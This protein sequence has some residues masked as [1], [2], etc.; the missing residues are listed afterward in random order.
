MKVFIIDNSI[1]TNMANYVGNKIIMSMIVNK[2]QVEYKG[3][4]TETSEHIYIFI[5]V[6]FI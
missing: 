4:N 3:E 2:I 5:E 6:R 1:D